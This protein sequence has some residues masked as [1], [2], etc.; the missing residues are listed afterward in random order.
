MPSKRKTTATKEEAKPVL[1]PK[2]RFPEFRKAAEWE[3]KP[4][5]QLADPVTAR[6]SLAESNTVLTLSAEYGIIPQGDYFGKK[7][8]GDNLERYLKI[9]RND[10]VYNDRTTKAYPFGTIKRLA[11]CDS[12]LVSPIYKCFRFKEGENPLFWNW[13]FESG[14]HEEEL[15]KLVNEGARTGRFNISIEKFLSI[16]VWLPKPKEQ[17][18]IADCLS[19]LDDLITSESQKIE[20]LKTH[21]KGLMRR[22]FPFE[23]EAEV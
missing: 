23:K 20:A 3:K 18:K 1:E 16:S 4:L 13:Y 8:A 9:I 15:N 21:K 14:F 6:A 11:V 19:S 17:T 7:I 12:G 22:L 5:H 10:F 2:L